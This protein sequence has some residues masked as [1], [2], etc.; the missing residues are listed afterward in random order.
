MIKNYGLYNHYEYDNTLLIL[1]SDASVD[2]I[3][4]V[5]E[6]DVLYH[7]NQKVGYRIKNFIRYAKIKY[8]GIIFLPADPLID[9][10]NSI[11]RKYKLEILDYKKHSGYVTKKCDNK[12]MVHATSGTFL[13]D[14]TIS[15]GK[16]CTYY[17]L[18]IKSENEHQLI[19]FDDQ[20]N[21]NVDFFQM[22]VK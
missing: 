8:S 10:V 20:I 15:Q 7:D 12:V 22:E 2:K 1:F 18:Y 21:E 11:L 16:F 13:R 14:E 17:D 6:V 5:S 3:E 9:I 19:E 4:S